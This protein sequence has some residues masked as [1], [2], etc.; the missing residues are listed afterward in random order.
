M[1]LGA[2]SPSS[3]RTLFSPRRRSGDG[4]RPASGGLNLEGEGPAGEGLD[5]DLHGAVREYAQLR[6]CCEK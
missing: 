2:P 6:A 3:P 4:A 5:E 1:L